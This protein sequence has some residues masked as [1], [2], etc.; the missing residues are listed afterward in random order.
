MNP[1]EINMYVSKLKEMAKALTLAVP[2]LDSDVNR[3]ALHAQSLEL[4]M[5]LADLEN[6]ISLLNSQSCSDPVS[7]TSMSL[8]DEDQEVKKLKGRL[9]RWGNNPNQI[10]SR[11]LALFLK[12][13]KKGTPVTVHALKSAYGKDGEFEKNFPQMKMISER[14]HGKVFEVTDGIVTIWPKVAAY[15][16]EFSKQVGI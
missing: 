13:S 2:K 16:D 9:P 6:K 10:N 11:I 15:V 3:A 1:Q 4:L 8:F 14:N 5:G 12:L 7:G